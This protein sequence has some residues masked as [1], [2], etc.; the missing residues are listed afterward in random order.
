M[1]IFKNVVQIIIKF[2]TLPFIVILFILFPD[3]FAN[4]GETNTGKVFSWSI[5]FQDIDYESLKNELQKD[6]LNFSYTNNEGTFIWEYEQINYSQDINDLK[7]ILYQ[8]FLLQFFTFFFHLMRIF[9]TFKNDLLW[10]K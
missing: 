7:D 10:K 6:I 4:T 8:M 3:C 1:R 9:Y 2:I 5:I